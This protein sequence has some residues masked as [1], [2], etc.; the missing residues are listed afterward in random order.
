MPG[1]K[2]SKRR[3]LKSGRP[4]LAR[5]PASM[6]R[7]TSSSTVRTFHQLRK[8]LARAVDQGREQEAEDLDGRIENQGGLNRYQ[9]ASMQ[10]QARDRGG[11]SSITLMGWLKELTSDAKSAGQRLRMLEVGA[12]S[13]RNACSKSGRLNITRIDLH[14]QDPDIL[15]QDFMKRPVPEDTSQQF[16]IISLSL[17]LNF[18]S[19]DAERGEML[20][21]TCHFLDKSPKQETPRSW[22]SALPALFLVLPAACVINSRYLS[23]QRLTNMAESLGYVPFRRKQTSKLVYYL[24]TWSGIPKPATF[25]KKQINK[26]TRMNNFCV[27]LNG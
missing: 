25:A 8:Q 15:Q 5:M 17:V 6:S 19:L 13:T 16:D 9:V 26:G 14:S 2:S 4:P 23:E 21:R 1:R 3:S 10:G 20:K 24:W 11:D 7:K 12:L 22:K 18:V 27:V